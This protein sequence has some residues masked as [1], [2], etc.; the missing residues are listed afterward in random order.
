MLPIELALECRVDLQVEAHVLSA[1]ILK[2][3]NSPESLLAHAQLDLPEPFLL[4]APSFVILL[5]P[6]EFSQHPSIAIREAWP[7]Q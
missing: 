5:T 4:F 7:L 1:A 2:L 3:L 6:C